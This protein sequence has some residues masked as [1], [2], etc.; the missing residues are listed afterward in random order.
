MHE[1]EDSCVSKGATLLTRF[2]WALILNAGLAVGEIVMS[3]ITGSTA[4]LADGLNNLDDT[5]ALVLSIYSERAARRPAD[6][7]H[8][9]GHQRIDVLAGF[10]KGCLLLFAAVLIVYK[11]AYFL[12]EPIEIP[13]VAV[14]I[15]ASI[16]L[17]VNLA[18]AFWLKEDA[19]HSLNAK[20]TYLCMVYDAVGSVAVM[21]SGVAMWLWDFPYF[22]VAASAVI[23]FFMTKSGLSLLREATSVFMQT[24]PKS[25]KHEEF[26]SAVKDIPNVTAIGD[27]HVWSHVPNEHHLTCRVAVEVTEC[28]DCNRIVKSVEDLCS[29]F[30]IQHS[31]I[32]LVYDPTDVPH[33]CGAPVEFSSDRHIASKRNTTS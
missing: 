3:L 18:S 17:V 9:F 12:M 22:D 20:G 5:A 7:R 8:T 24:A 1:H 19:C 13:G 30:D 6:R 32:Q 29:R 2:V 33:D 14:L 25:F 31:T 21:I 23:V 11:A 28:C 16:A 15:T 10:A 26:E 27:I 4:L